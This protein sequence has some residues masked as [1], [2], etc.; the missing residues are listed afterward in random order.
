MKWLANLLPVGLLA[1]LASAAPIVERQLDL[2]QLQISCPGN[3]NVDGRFLALQNNTLG[4]F[5]GDNVA[6]VQVYPVDSEKEGCNELHTYPV[7][8]V[9]H[10]I[11]LLGPPGLLTLVDMMNPR[12]IQPGDGTIAQWDTFRI[13]DGKL[14]NDAD[15]QW[16]AF[17]DGRGSWKVKW[18]DGSAVITADFMI[19]DVLYKSVGEGRYNGI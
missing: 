3:K 12:T 13:A 9:D 15:G 5:D 6:P 18:S 19:V 16:L 10:S 17:P 2:Y 14:A 4:V 11:A 8:I 1:A 7:G